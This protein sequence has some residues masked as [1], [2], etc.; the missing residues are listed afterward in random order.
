MTPGSSRPEFEHVLPRHP[1][2]QAA[3]PQPLVNGTHEQ[4]DDV[5][6]VGLGQPRGQS[7]GVERLFGFVDAGQHAEPLAP[8]GV[9]I[10]QRLL[11]GAFCAVAEYGLAENAHR[12]SSILNAAMAST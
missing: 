12:V 5:A 8:L 1:H 2:L 10:G 3:R 11:D 9:D 6:V 4:H 7:H